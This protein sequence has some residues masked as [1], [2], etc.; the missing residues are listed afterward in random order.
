MFSY[1]GS[2][3]R[4]YSTIYGVFSGDRILYAIEIRNMNIVQALGRDNRSIPDNDKKIVNEWFRK[5]Y[6]R[7]WI[8][9][10][11]L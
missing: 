5:V 4:K 10:E 3:L 7:E 9:G 1:S 11:K 6:T 8:G 2:I